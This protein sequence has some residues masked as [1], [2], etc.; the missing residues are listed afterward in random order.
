MAGKQQSISLGEAAERLGVHYMTAYRW[1]RIGR[2]PATKDGTEWR[3]DPADVDRAR[4]DRAFGTD[5]S[6]RR[7]T[8]P[9]SAARERLERRL[10][11]GDEAGAWLIVESALTSGAVPADVHLELLLPS[12][13]SIGQ[14]WSTHELTVAD[15]HRASAL[16]HRLV[17][18]LGPRFNRPGKKRG[19]IVLGAVAGDPHALPTA[20]L[21]D[22]VR[23]TGFEVFDLGANTPADDF[24]VA[25]R[26]VPHLLAVGIGCACD[27]G[28]AAVAS[29]VD[30]VRAEAP[31]IM[32]LLGG[33]A[34][35]TERF[36]RQVGAD[37]WARDAR[38]LLDAL[39]RAAQSRH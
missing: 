21:A 33:P 5:R 2:L 16:A 19:G 9:R 36:V 39:E 27:E 13:V 35:R 1:I 17:G 29:T 22:L 28:R 38:S 37:L 7:P 14:R 34:I 18:R 23:G 30:A 15:E 3:L 4:A 26:E 20:I 12:L 32:V 8:K 11:A 31:D 10:L 25:M 24:A 6:E